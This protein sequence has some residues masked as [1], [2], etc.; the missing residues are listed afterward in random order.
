MARPTHYPLTT[1]ETAEALTA[2][3]GAGRQISE[4]MVRRLFEDGLLPEPTRIGGK[5]VVWPC[6]LPRLAE[7]M[8][9]RGWLPEQESTGA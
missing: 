9:A 2:E 5:R 4:W 1:R 6:E 3:F 8:R 7:L